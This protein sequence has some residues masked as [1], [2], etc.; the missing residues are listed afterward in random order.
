MTDAK[1]YQ[2]RIELKRSSPPI[3]RRVAVPGDITLGGL[4]EVI[5]TV[6]GWENM[7]LHQFILRLDPAQLTIDEM[8]GMVESQGYDGLLGATRD[9][10]F[11]VPGHDPAG[12]PLG[13]EGED[14]YAVALAEVCPKVKSKIVYEY[15]FGDGWEHVI[16]VQKITDPDPDRALPVC[17]AGK[18]A[19]PPEDCGGTYGYYGLL[20]ALEDP[21][22]DRHDDALLWLGEDFDPEAIDIEAINRRLPTLR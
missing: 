14:E 22:H 13:M 20:E 9:R 2:L 3:W 15:D 10:R 4:H 7:H 19:G 21:T 16:T 17:L 12:G 18:R 1:T 5:Q 8:R 6:M 11:F